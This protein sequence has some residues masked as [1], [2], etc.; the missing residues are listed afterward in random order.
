MLLRGAQTPGELKARTERMASFSSLAEIERA[1]QTLIDRGYAQR[2]PR[3]PGQKED[4]F[5]Q[6]LGGERPE[7][8]SAAAPVSA[9]AP[10]IEALVARLNEL[11]ER[12]A[13]LRQELAEL[14]VGAL[15]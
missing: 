9:S 10:T 13:E 8:P 4:R 7:V 14:R 3:R 6:L 1:L 12:V 2:A 11:E 15:D 5:E